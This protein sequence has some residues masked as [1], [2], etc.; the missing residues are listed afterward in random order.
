[1]IK[2]GFV[3]IIIPCYNKG[4]YLSDTINTI[5]NQSYKNW[6]CII[7]DDGS[8]D[9]SRQV[10]ESFCR[11]DSKIKYV[12]KENSGV[13]DARN[14]GI[15]LSTGEYIIFLDADDTLSNEKL[16]AT[17]EEFKKN[18]ELNV[19][20]SN[21]LFIF[22]N[23]FTKPR[24][25]SFRVKL[26]SDVY[27]DIIK[28]WDSTLLVPIHACIY[29]LSFLRK[30]KILF[31]NTLKNREDWDFLIQVA[32]KTN[33]FYYV[34][35]HLCSYRVVPKSRSTNASTMITGTDELF[36]KHMNVNSIKSIAFNLRYRIIL[37]QIYTIVG[38]TRDIN[39]LSMY[40]I[41]NSPRFKLYYYL[42]TPFAILSIIRMTM[43]KIYRSLK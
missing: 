10:A 34:D 17:I 33:Y 26:K 30:N 13:A 39:S 19:V 1:M 37:N 38:K 4:G 35:Q 43:Y 24:K 42:Q 16:T 15:D 20:Y 14:V 41:A 36:H 7:V 28:S 18:P 12:W 6:E 2:I 11:L 29:R 23:D 25:S 32:M 8:S 21:F 5:L 40:S 22:N 9:N 27:T 3:S 31:C